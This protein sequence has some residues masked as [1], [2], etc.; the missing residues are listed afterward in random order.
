MLTVLRKGIYMSK[1]ANISIYNIYAKQ[2][3]YN[4]IENKIMFVQEIWK[5]FIL[6]I[7]FYD[8]KLI[9]FTRKTLR[10]LIV[11]IRGCANIWIILKIEESDENILSKLVS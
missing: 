3:W 4:R 7:K 9:L 8:G 2:S 10:T 1:L 6:S 5:K 11:D